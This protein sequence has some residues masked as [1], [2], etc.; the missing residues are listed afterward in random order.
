LQ[1]INKNIQQKSSLPAEISFFPAVCIN[2]AKI[3][4]FGGYD[5]VEKNQVKQCEIYDIEKD[6][7]QR[8]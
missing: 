6:Q 5:N 3:Y 8:N 2:A 4:T 7:W 1:Y